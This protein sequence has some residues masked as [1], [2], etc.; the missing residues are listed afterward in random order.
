ME[1]CLDWISKAKAYFELIYN[2]K[3]R[4]WH[5]ICIIQMNSSSSVLQ[6]KLISNCNDIKLL[7]YADC[8]LHWQSRLV[9]IF[10][11]FWSGKWYFPFHS[12]FF[13][14][15]FVS[16]LNFFLLTNVFYSVMAAI[17]FVLLIWVLLYGFYS[18]ESTNICLK[19]N[20]KH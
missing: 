20:E 14:I 13:F 17:Y 2:T 3:I 4:C 12:I 5:K 7:K 18:I 16:E 19:I 6:S 10:Y 11:F 9:L 8:F 15:V 1:F